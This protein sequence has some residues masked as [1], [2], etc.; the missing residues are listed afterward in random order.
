MIIGIKII[1]FILITEGI[2]TNYIRLIFTVLLSFIL[3]VCSLNETI[4]Y[5]FTLRII[6]E[7]GEHIDS[8]DYKR[9]TWVLIIDNDNVK[10]DEILVDLYSF[11]DS[12]FIY[13]DT[14]QNYTANYLEH[15]IPIKHMIVCPSLNIKLDKD[16]TYHVEAKISNK[17]NAS[18]FLYLKYGNHCV[19][20]FDDE[21][22]IFRI[23]DK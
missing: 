18:Y 9:V 21:D 22:K 12:D 11:D 13:I 20:S 5:D 1:E 7:Y 15:I 4:H 23:Y 10:D 2:K 6:K 3:C 19:V 14:T 16:G 8:T 17:K